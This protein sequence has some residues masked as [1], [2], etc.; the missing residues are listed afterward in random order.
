MTAA[1]SKSL[2][3]KPE[4]SE[5]EFMFPIKWMWATGWNLTKYDETELSSTQVA[6]ADKIN[7]NDS[8]KIKIRNS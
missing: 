8:H 5:T 2:I 1:L 7:K 3:I 4:W 6:N